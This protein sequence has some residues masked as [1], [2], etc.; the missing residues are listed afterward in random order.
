[1][2]P[3]PGDDPNSDRGGGTP[4]SRV[5]VNAI[6]SFAATTGLS[7]AARRTVDAMLDAG[8]DVAIEDYDYGARRQ[9]SRF[10]THMRQLPRGRPHDIDICFLNVNEIQATPEEFLREPGRDRYLIGSWYWELPTIPPTIARQVERVDEVWTASTFV[11][12][13]FRRHTKKPVHVI[14]CVVEPV[15]DLNVTRADFGIPEDTVVCFFSFDAHSTIARKNPRGVI[16]AFRRATHRDERGRNV[17]LV[18]KSINLERLPEA[19]FFLEN[20]L[21]S[22]GGIMIDDDLKSGEMNALLSTCD[23]YL[24]L[25]RSEGLGLGLAEAMFFGKPVIA[26]A[27]SGNM[28]FTHA[29]NSCLVPY[30]LVP[31]RLADLRFN[32]GAQLVYEPGQ[33]WAE[34]NVA[35]AARRLRFLI[36]NPH[37]RERIGARAAADIR[38][39]YGAAAVGAELRS[40]L[41]GLTGRERVSDTA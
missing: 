10:P 6:A 14:P 15:A 36:D 3:T 12:D 19:R 20:E 8:I 37:A 17:T 22:V 39:G 7:E 30:Q 26:T 27:Y 21:A 9:S 32:P 38:S 33:L 4:R 41:S 25:H 2:H 24:S 18:M 40:V 31:V 11:R 16:E 29:A 5:A 1:V 34:A 35:V 13:A 23:I 28:D